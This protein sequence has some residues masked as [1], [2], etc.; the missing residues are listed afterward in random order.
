MLS[1]AELAGLRTTL[2]QSLPDTAQVLR[3]GTVSDGMGG[4]TGTWA[5]YG[6]AVACRVSPAGNSPSERVLADRVQGRQLWVVTLPAT[7]D[8]GTQDRLA[9]GTRTFEVMGTSAPRS[10]ELQRRLFC[11]EV[12]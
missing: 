5:N 1:S 2:D 4:N 7:T 3:L 9:V 12:V 10:Y 6:S 11:V 8:I